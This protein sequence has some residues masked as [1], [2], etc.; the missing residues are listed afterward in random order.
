MCMKTGQ[1]AIHQKFKHKTKNMRMKIWQRTVHQNFVHETKNLC[2]KTR[3]KTIH[4]KFVHKIAASSHARKHKV[5]NPGGGQ[6]TKNVCM[7]TQRRPVDQKFEHKNRA[8]CKKTGWRAVSRE[9]RHKSGAAL[10]KT[11]SW[12][13]YIT[14]TCPNRI[15]LGMNVCCQV[16]LNWEINP[17][18]YDSARS[19][20][21]RPN[22]AN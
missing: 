6:L 19:E 3:Q 8:D 14:V 15:G 12:L 9:F 2:I 1:R 7:K 11:C 20:L 17:P 5:G 21:C 4:Q 22:V 13:L 18:H 16:L 10:K